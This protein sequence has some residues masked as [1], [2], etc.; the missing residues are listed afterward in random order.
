M[1][2]EWNI[3]LY[4]LTVQ[5]GEEEKAVLMECRRNSVAR[6]TG[7]H[8]LPPSLLGECYLFSCAGVLLTAGSVVTLRTLLGTGQH[9]D[10]C[11]PAPM[12]QLPLLPPGR[13]P[14]H[15][16]R[17]SSVYYTAVGVVSFLAGMRSYHQRCVD[18][19]M[20]LEHSVLADQLRQH[21][22]KQ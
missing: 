9:V 5:L 22:R 16:Q 15:V 3:P 12:L 7:I 10:W 4:C 2:L 13:I 17:W 19:L 1:G 8:L 11:V 20:S 18:K 14:L 21:Q 6:G